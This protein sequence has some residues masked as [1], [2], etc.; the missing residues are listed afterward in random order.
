[1]GWRG[2][3]GCTGYMVLAVFGE[4]KE[5]ELQIFTNIHFMDTS[6]TCYDV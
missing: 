3:H 4:F 5:L 1:M 2:V 6:S